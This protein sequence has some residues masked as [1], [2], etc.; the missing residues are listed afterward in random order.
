M[1]ALALRMGQEL[2]INKRSELTGVSDPTVKRWLRL[3][4]TAGLI[5]LL[6]P[7]FSNKTKTLVKSPKI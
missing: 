6:P 4:E 2:R 5:Y 3:A 1:K 7:F